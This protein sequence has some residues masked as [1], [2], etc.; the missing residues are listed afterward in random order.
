VTIAESFE[1]CRSMGRAALIPYLMAGD[2][3]LDVSATLIAAVVDAGADLVEIG[4]PYSDPLADGLTIQAAGQRALRA[5]ATFDAV[6]EMVRGLDRSKIVAPLLAF[7]YYNPL[8]V[9]G[10]ARSARDLAR[11]GFS[12]A[13]VPDLPLEEAEAAAASFSS[14]GVGLTLLVAPTT[15]QARAKAI[16]AASSGFVYVVSRLGVTGARASLSTDVADLVASVRPLTAKPL[17]VGFGVSTPAQAAAIARIA[18]GVVVG[19]ALVDCVARAGTGREA[20]AA[21]EFCAALSL[22]MTK[23]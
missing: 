5:G 3:T 16:A 23:S 15:P 19:S 7:T 14:E 20:G 11:A 6:L 9:R 10:L 21:R 4:I 13:I 8:F 17:A 1:R 18:D 12:G 22:A 2:P